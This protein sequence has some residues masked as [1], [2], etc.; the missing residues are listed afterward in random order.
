MSND[1]A[2]SF[3]Q[4]S[5][6][7]SAQFTL[8][9]PDLSFPKHRITAVLGESG[10]GKSS[11]LRLCNG[12][13]TPSQGNVSIL[14]QAIDY[15]DLEQLRLAIGFAVQGSALFPHLTVR[16]NIDIM[17]RLQGW[18]ESKRAQ[19][20][21]QLLQ[22][23]QLSADLLTSY[24]Q[25]LSGGQQQRVSLSRALMLQPE[26]LLLDEPFSALDP[27]TRKNLQQ[28][29]RRLQQQHDLSIVLVTHDVTEAL[30][31]ADYLV[32]MRAGEVLQAGAP[33]AV[34]E[35]PNDEYVATLL[36]SAR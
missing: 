36:E 20:I 4:L 9:L 12:L 19:R 26:L 15:G 29:L 18:S 16:H 25:Q 6:R 10:S 17:A 31:L 24:P 35:Q 11:L 8:S 1:Y 2:V 22:T 7:L 28:H 32:V 21:D 34:L 30:R 14:G 13:L 27:I 3:S 5:L 33:D 23:M